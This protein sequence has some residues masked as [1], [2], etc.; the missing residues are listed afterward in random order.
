MLKAWSR[1][2]TWVRGWCTGTLFCQLLS[3]NLLPPCHLP[4]MAVF[5]HLM[6]LN[7]RDQ[8]WSH[9]LGLLQILRRNKSR[10][11]IQRTGLQTEAF[12]GPRSSSSSP[13]L[14]WLNSNSQ[15]WNFNP[16]YNHKP[17]PTNCST[18]FCWIWSSLP[19]SWHHLLTPVL[20]IHWIHLPPFLHTHD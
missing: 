17:P 11:K 1:T 13:N 6:G 3:F 14:S 16:C 19:G 2:V 5:L 7:K 9:G 12:P 10:L 8:Q 4:S 20:Q 18:S 15:T